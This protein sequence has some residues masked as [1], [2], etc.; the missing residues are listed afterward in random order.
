M[1]RRAKRPRSC[2]RRLID[3]ADATTPQFFLNS[4]EVVKDLALLEQIFLVVL[5][6][7][8]SPGIGDYSVGALIQLVLTEAMVKRRA[9]FSSKT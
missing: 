3:R 2:R 4:I 8:N 9:G 7:A 5:I 1:W 6:V